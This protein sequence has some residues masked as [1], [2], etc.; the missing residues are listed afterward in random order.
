[1]RLRAPTRACSGQKASAAAAA[2]AAEFDAAAGELDSYLREAR[3]L[4]NGLE[5]D[6]KVPFSRLSEH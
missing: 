5:A 1:V 3:R 2:A 4:W 6:M